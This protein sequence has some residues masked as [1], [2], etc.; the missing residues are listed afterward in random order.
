MKSDESLQTEVFRV[1]NKGNNPN[2]E[3]KRQSLGTSRIFPPLNG[4]DDVTAGE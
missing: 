1:C 4:N 2:I 3:R